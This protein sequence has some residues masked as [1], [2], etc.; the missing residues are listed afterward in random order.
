MA[1]TGLAV[2]DNFSTEVGEDVSQIVALVSPRVTPLLNEIG[3]AQF[4]AES[5]YHTWNEKGLN[6]TSTVL[7]SAVASSAGTSEGFRVSDNSWIRAFDIFLNFGTSEQVLV[8]S[9]SSSGN[10]IYVTRAYAGTLANSSAQ[11][12]SLTFLGSALPEGSGARK[13]RHK[14]KALK[15]NYVQTFREDIIISNRKQFV[16]PKVE[17][18][19]SPY[20]ED[21]MDR[22]MEVLRQLENAV[23][24]GRTNGNT[25]GAADVET[26]MAG[27]YNSIVTNITSHA[28][29][30][31][32]ILGVLL[33]NMDAYTDVRSNSD[34]YLLM[35]GNRA[36][37]L[38]NASVNSRLRQ[39]ISNGNGAGVAGIPASFTYLT[40][41]GVMR[42]INNKWAPTGSV[43]AVRK[44]LIKVLP[45][46][47]NSFQQRQYED[48]DSAKKGYVEG[49]YTVEFHQE[50]VHG[51]LD[52]LSA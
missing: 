47:G 14:G 28:T 50:A 39:D 31:N 41:F 51:R 27:I 20:D 29:F 2:Y 30:S 45:L 32:S 40:D 3:D 4:Y 1:F 18:L 6:P 46:R 34:N 48:G 12:D 36:Y 7:S 16:K 8:T 49:T 22:T 37:S 21:L 43:M 52:G 17:G 23:I 10:T 13:Q 5:S 25:I 15:G 24:M 26:T 38:I 19:P 42:V 11:G 9:V 35:A 44:D 33:R